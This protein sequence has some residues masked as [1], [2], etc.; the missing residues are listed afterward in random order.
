MHKTE[1][2]HRLAMT[3]G[4]D[5]VVL[6]HVTI[7]G[8]ALEQL[9]SAV[10]KLGI[11]PV[12]GG[13]HDDLPTHMSVVGFEDGSYVELIAKETAGTA[14]Y[15]DR[16]MDADAGPCAWAIQSTDIDADTAALRAAGIDVDGPEPYSRDRPDGTTARWQLA[17]P[18]DGEPGTLLPFLIED[19]TPRSRRVQPTP[20]AATAGLVG[21]AE[22]ILAVSELSTA[23]ETMTRAFETAAPTTGDVETGP[24]A[25]S[26]A[27]FD[28]LPV[29]LVEPGPNDPLAERLTTVGDGPCG[30][31]FEATPTAYEQI[32][33]THSQPLGAETIEVIDPAAV[34]GLTYLALTPAAGHAR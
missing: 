29:T 33:P 4:D 16:A 17:F 20:S 19:T 22:V 25:G 21:T 18:G 2:Y 27:R 1:A 7:A 13:S 23:R 3:L 5:D 26:V 11:E 30:F 24:F 15:W 12:F 14:P 28:A 9:T 6:D 32:E 10:E 31:V 34:G 8:T